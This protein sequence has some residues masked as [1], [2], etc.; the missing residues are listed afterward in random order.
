MPKGDKH[1]VFSA[2]TTEE[3]LKVLNQL[4]GDLKL[5]WDELVI[6]AINIAYSNSLETDIPM[7]LKAEPKPKVDKPAKAEKKTK[8]AEGTKPMPDAVFE[9]IPT[10]AIDQSLIAETAAGD[11]VKA[12]TGE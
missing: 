9:S 3:G 10:I 6:N 5:S 4:K 7:L 1:H 2:R 12:E 11:V 8:K